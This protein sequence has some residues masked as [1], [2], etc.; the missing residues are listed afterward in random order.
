M[1]DIW[2]HISFIKPGNSIKKINILFFLKSGGLEN[3]NIH[4]YIYLYYIYIYKNISKILKNI[5]T[6]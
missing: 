2:S 6:K 3:D 5:L 4:K 1:Q